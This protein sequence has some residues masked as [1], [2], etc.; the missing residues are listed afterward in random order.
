MAQITDLGSL[1]QAIKDE[2]NRQEDD[3]VID[4]FIQRA[5][6][7]I[8]R[9]GRAIQK[10]VVRNYFVQEDTTDALVFTGDPTL[11]SI[12]EIIDVAVVGTQETFNPDGTGITLGTSPRDRRQLGVR[13]RAALQTVI[14]VARGVTGPL[15]LVAPL[16]ASIIAVAPIADKNYVLECDLQT[17]TLLDKAV[18]ASTTTL[19][20]DAPDLYLYGSLKQTAGFFKE[21]ERLPVW[22]GLFQEAREE[23][24]LQYE[25]LKFPSALDQPLQRSFGTFIHDN[26]Y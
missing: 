1:R 17:F 6:S 10:E 24:E 21:E 5:E 8:R 18:D 7:S 26:R 23:L 16:T 22:Q 12:E 3:A 13:N 25:R 20:Q 19:L 15:E 11:F 9:I 14:G 4:G 2:L